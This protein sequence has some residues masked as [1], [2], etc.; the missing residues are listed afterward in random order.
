MTKGF[1][2]LFWLLPFT[3]PFF[4]FCP[5]TL[6]SLNPAFPS[7]TAQQDTLAKSSMVTSFFWTKYS[8]KLG[9]ETR[10]RGDPRSRAFL[11]LWA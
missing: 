3:H 6:Q 7:R 2:F 9:L 11:D 10:K 5:L 8:V 1:V 4:T